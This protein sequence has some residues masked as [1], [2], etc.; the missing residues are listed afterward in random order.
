MRQKCLPVWVNDKAQGRLRPAP[1]QTHMS[2]L[3]QFTVYTFYCTHSNE[4]GKTVIFS[5]A[6]EFSTLVMWCEVNDNTLW[7]MRSSSETALQSLNTSLFSITL[8]HQLPRSSTQQPLFTPLWRAITGETQ[9]WQCRPE[10]CSTTHS[11]RHILTDT[12]TQPFLSFL[13]FYSIRAIQS[14][15]F[16]TAELSG[17]TCQQA[18]T[19]CM[20]PQNQQRNHSWI[21]LEWFRAKGRQS[22]GGPYKST[23]QLI[24]AVYNWFV[25]DK[26]RFMFY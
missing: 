7:C 3:L 14:Q 2:N 15:F 16:S 19:T 21:K 17:T 11:H 13:F 6:Y 8:H 24:S 4:T 9:H 20:L 1:S 25:F 22:L 26:L 23:A 10:C 5:N 12:H 18:V